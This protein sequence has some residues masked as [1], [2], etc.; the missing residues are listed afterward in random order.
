MPSR[1]GK[2][3]LLA[4]ERAP[5]RKLFTSTP[6]GRALATRFVAGETL[7]D[8]VGVAAE[9]NEGGFAVSLD[10]L[11]EHVADPDT[12]RV[13]RDDYLACLDAISTLGLDANISVKLTQLGLGLDGDL[14]AASLDELAN[15]A[16]AANTT[17]TVDMEESGHTAATVDLYES[18]QREH[19][20]LGIALQAYLLRTA[21]DLERLAPLGGHIRLCK[22]AYLE[23]PD[24]AFQG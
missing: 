12:A 24:I 17:V 4:T 10:H 20:N 2:L 6:P 1:L 14:A 9:L 21:G 16:A 13:A 3:L 18:A 19:G 15:R 5:V 7:E 8:A 22:G 23:P 11:G